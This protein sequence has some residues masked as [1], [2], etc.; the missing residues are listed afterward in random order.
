[1]KHTLGKTG[2]Q[3]TRDLLDQGVGS[4][5]GIVLASELLDELLVLVQ[6]LQ[7]IGAHGIH[8]TVLGTIDIMLVTE[9][10]IINQPSP[11]FFQMCVC[12]RTK[13]SCR[14]GERQGDGRFQRNACHAE[15]HSS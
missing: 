3:K 11:S 6:L 5:E 14:G 13:C 2:T 9:N 12:R 4:N 15:D 1:M 10:T 8:T 7:V